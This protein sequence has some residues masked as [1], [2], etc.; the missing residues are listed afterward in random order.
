MPEV[1]NTNLNLSDYRLWEA[2]LDC[3][4]AVISP[5]PLR[6][7]LMH[8]AGL[9]RDP[10]QLSWDWVSQ[11][12]DLGFSVRCYG[13]PEQTCWQTQYFS[14]V[15]K[16]R[17]LVKR[18]IRILTLLLTVCDLGKVLSLRIPIKMGRIIGLLGL[19]ENISN[20]SNYHLIDILYYPYNIFHSYHLTR[21]TYQF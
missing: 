5:S 21:W 4:I 15:L 14:T 2:N 20:N 12:V 10:L 9:P 17:D 11:K 7:A 6:W 16:C 13:K 19:G 1:Q 3:Q 18:E 8:A